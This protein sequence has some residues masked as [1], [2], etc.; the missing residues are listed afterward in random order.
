MTAEAAER[1]PRNGRFALPIT[2]NLDQ[3]LGA[4]PKSARGTRA[5]RG[6]YPARYERD[7]HGRVDLTQ[8]NGS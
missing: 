4:R 1:R 5:L 3:E 7:V 2:V 6:G 8:N